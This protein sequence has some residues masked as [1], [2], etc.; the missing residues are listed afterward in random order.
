M[1]GGDA[2]LGWERRQRVMFSPHEVT[3][4]GKNVTQIEALWNQYR[5][6]SEGGNY[7]KEI[8]VNSDNLVHL[9]LRS[10][11]NP[12]VTAVIVR[13]RQVS[14]GMLFAQARAVLKEYDAVG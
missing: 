2:G 8:L 6:V 14:I 11:S 10:A 3:E 1:V 9:F 7:F 4:Q 13:T 5:G 12:E